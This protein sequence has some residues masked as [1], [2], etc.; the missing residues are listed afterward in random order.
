[1]EQTRDPKSCPLTT[2]RTLWCTHSHRQAHT[3]PKP[4]LKDPQ[5]LERQPLGLKIIS[6][7]P[8]WVAHGLQL[9]GMTPFSGLLRNLH[10][11]VHIHTH[12]NAQLEK[13]TQSFQK[14][15]TRDFLGMDLRPYLG[16]SERKIWQTIKTTGSQSPCRKTAGS[17]VFRA[18]SGGD[19]E[20]LTDFSLLVYSQS[21]SSQVQ[22]QPSLL[23]SIFQS[24]SVLTRNHLQR[25]RTDK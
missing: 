4:I 8:S 22:V 16:S 3:K 2:T 14:S 10:S 5:E 11:H 12:I 17:H 6:Q 24:L 21:C 18:S 20:F 19:K 9:Q 13:N 25:V 23:Q 7:H 15:S 1:M